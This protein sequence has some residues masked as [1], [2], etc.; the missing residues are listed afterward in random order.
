MNGAPWWVTLAVGALTAAAALGGTVIASWRQNRRAG[1]EEWFRRVQWAQGLTTS[2]DD[3][4]REAG[5]RLLDNL[6]TS[7]LATTDDQEL[8]LELTHSP[9]LAAAEIEVQDVDDTAFVR[10]NEDDQTPQEGP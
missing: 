10:D 2:P 6:S 4:T 3:A 9:A 5:Y 1:R 8:L 7:P